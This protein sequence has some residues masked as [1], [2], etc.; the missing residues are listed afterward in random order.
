MKEKLE[1]LEENAFNSLRNNNF[2]KAISQYISLL[3]GEIGEKDKYLTYAC[4]SM[5]LRLKKACFSAGDMT[6]GAFMNMDKQVSSEYFVAS[7]FHLKGIE[8]TIS[9]KNVYESAKLIESMLEYLTN[10]L[11]SKYALNIHVSVLCGIGD[12]SKCKMLIKKTQTN[13]SIP[14]SIKEQVQRFS[15][16]INEHKR[17]SKEASKHVRGFL[18]E[19]MFLDSTLVNKHLNQIQEFHIEF[20]GDINQSETDSS[21]EPESTRKSKWKFWRK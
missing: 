14:T 12:Y 11:K 21:I 19:L 16:S 2:D 7:L 3:R 17:K 8:M 13:D 4:Y 6:I 20:C 10:E 15:D 18:S 9:A 5:W 1:L